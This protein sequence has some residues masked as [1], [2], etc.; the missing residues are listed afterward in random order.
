[1]RIST[2]CQHAILTSLLL[3]RAD[4]VVTTNEMHQKLGI[5]ISYLEQLLAILRQKGI[6]E[7][8]RGPGGGY[9]LAR[10]P[11]HITAEDIVRAFQDGGRQKSLGRADDLSGLWQQFCQD[12]WQFLGDRTLKQMAD[13]TPAASC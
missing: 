5:S 13:P 3:A 1:M 10:H 7:A 6:V 11:E 12:T 8:I 4:K 2:R 9:Q